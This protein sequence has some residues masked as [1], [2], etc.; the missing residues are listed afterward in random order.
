MCYNEVNKHGNN[1]IKYDNEGKEK[2]LSTSEKEEK[3][4]DGY[5]SIYE[6]GGSFCHLTYKCACTATDYIKDVSMG[7]MVEL[8]WK[9]KSEFE[10]I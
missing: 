8:F 7:L 9:Y 3:S 10:D 5:F 6:Y 1:L 2:N 4:R